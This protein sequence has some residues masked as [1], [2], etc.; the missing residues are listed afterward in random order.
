[1]FSFPAVATV[2]FMAS[3]SLVMFVVLLEC[4]SPGF[5]DSHVVSSVVSAYVR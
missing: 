2:T 3:M 4:D 1:M 5:L